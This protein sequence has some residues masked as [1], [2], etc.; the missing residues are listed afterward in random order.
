[1]PAA[2]AT[3]ATLMG[4]SL[5]PFWPTPLL[6]LL[7]LSAGLVTVRAPRAGL[8]LAL[9]APV[10]PLGNVAQAAAVVYGVLA[11]GWLAANWHDARAGLAFFAGPLLAPL[12][13]IALLPLAVQP[14]RGIWR[15]ALHAG[16]GVYAAAAVAALSGKGLPLGGDTVP[17]LGVAQS[18]RPGDVLH[19]LGDVLRTHPELST[20][21][22]AFALVAALLPRAT[23]R[24]RVGIAVLGA[25]QVAL[26][27]L[28]APSIPW[29]PMLLGTVLQCGL[30]AAWPLVR[31]VV[32]TRGRW[33]GAFLSR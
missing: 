14:A 1:M 2:L 10:F 7:A 11:L 28:W 20:T 26:V 17:D 21:A 12:G 33:V 5:L 23:A 6:L 4:G 9:A 16:A 30:L 25:L 31:E 22:L 24:G 27:M 13:L 29:L 18:E 3:V 8:A 15:R 32:R 19:A